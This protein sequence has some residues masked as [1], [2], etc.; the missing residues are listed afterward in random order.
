M[1]IERAPPSRYFLL[2]DSGP[3]DDAECSAIEGTF[4]Q[5]FEV[6]VVLQRQFAR[7]REAETDAVWL[8]RKVRFENAVSD[9]RV[10]TW[11]AVREQD[12]E[13]CC[14]ALD[15]DENLA[16]FDWHPLEPV[17]RVLDEVEKDALHFR[18][19]DADRR[20]CLRQLDAY[21]FLGDL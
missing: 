7:Q 3:E 2:S 14:R 9:R 8:G 15:L 11:A 19:V 10:N 18:L 16:P 21:A 5:E 13:L 20:R 4:G 6:S 12:P 1:G 17:K